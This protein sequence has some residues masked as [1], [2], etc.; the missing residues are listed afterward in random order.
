MFLRK[1]RHMSVFAILLF[2]LEGCVPPAKTPMRTVYFTA[3]EPAGNHLLLVFLPGKGDQPESYETEGFVESVKKLNLPVDMLGADAHIGYYLQKNFLERLR[4]DVIMPAKARGYE[5][6][7]LIGISLGGLGALW[8][9]GSCPGDVEG[10]VSLAPYL[11]EPGMAREV[12]LA[13]GLAAWNPKLWRRMIC[14]GRYG[15]GSRSTCHPVEPCPGSI[16]DT[17]SRT[18]LPV[19]TA[20][21]PR[22][23]RAARFLPVREGM[24]GA[25]GDGSGPRSWV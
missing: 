17:A 12:S 9:D 20:S 19:R 4:K 24:T 16:W 22:H 10:I 1:A 18:G 5:R 8:Y 2:L 13:G 25:H 6:I 14:K 15:R 7:W 21:L 3:A 23:C 11:G